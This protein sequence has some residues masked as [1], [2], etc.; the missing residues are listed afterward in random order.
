MIESLDLVN[1]ILAIQ[2]GIL[3]IIKGN[4]KPLGLV[5]IV[6]GVTIFCQKLKIKQL[7]DR[8]DQHE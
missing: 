1:L 5:I 7:K 3:Q 8:E 6:Y 2:L 4:N